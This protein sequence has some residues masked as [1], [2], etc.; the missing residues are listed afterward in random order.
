MGHIPFVELPDV[1]AQAAQKVVVRQCEAIPEAMKYALDGLRHDR[2]VSD[3][4]GG[5]GWDWEEYIPGQLGPAVDVLGG[6]FD[7]SVLSPRVCR[8]NQRDSPGMV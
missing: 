7:G 3:L 6:R 5:G 4:P 8:R 2:P 1:V